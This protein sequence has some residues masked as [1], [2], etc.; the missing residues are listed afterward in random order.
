MQDQTTRQAARAIGQRARALTLEYLTGGIYV[1][2]R[3]RLFHLDVPML[4]AAV[5]AGTGGRDTPAVRRAVGRQA[6]ES[7]RA[8]GCS[9][10]IV[11]R[12]HGIAGRQ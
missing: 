10:P 6:I 3:R 11:V 1:S 9:W 4:T 12:Y 5:L 8:I 2:P 7:L